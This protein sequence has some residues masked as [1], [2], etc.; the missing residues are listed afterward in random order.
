MY[1]YV[2]IPIKS[3]VEKG[4]KWN[5]ERNNPKAKDIVLGNPLHE[6]V[7]GNEATKPN[8]EASIKVNFTTARSSPS[9]CT[10]SNGT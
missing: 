4:C 8:I 1:R 10:A 7:S 3:E 6:K 5:D 2:F 9:W